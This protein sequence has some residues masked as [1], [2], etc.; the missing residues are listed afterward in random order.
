[1]AVRKSN[2]SALLA[3]AVTFCLAGCE[4]IKALTLY[5]RTGKEI[6]VETSPIVPRY[7][8]TS[9]ADTAQSS[10]AG[11]VYRVSPDS[12]LPLITTFT[13]LL[14]NAKIK[15]NELPI[16]YLRI[17]TPTDTIIA[18]NSSE[19]I[20]LIKDSRLKYKKEDKNYVLATSRNINSIIIRQ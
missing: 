10:S 12:S 3:L 16:N 13:G 9:L 18:A 15:A 2:L 19:I 4:G 1:M 14:F 6:V 20:D 7:R 17:E 8:Y 11:M 5:N